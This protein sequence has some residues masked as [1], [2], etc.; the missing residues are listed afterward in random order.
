MPAVAAAA[1]FLYHGVQLV[2]LAMLGR[3]QSIHYCAVGAAW[4]GIVGP[5]THNAKVIVLWESVRT[6]NVVGVIRV[7]EKTRPAKCNV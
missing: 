6:G 4:C 5:P 3:E 2:L 1:F 7:K